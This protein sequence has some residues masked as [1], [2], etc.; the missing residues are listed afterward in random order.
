[1]KAVGKKLGA[2]AIEVVVGSGV[3]YTTGEKPAD[4]KVWDMSADEA[5]RA[6]KVAQ[7]LDASVQYVGIGTTSANDHL[8]AYSTANGGSGNTMVIGVGIAFDVDKTDALFAAVQKSLG[9]DDTVPM[10]IQRA[11]AGA[12]ASIGVNDRKDEYRGLRD[13]DA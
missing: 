9:V 12:L 6:T 8:G 1:M 4:T 3:A 7:K 2:D 11:E 10:V 13:G 5:K